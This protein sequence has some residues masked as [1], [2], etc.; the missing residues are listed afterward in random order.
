MSQPGEWSPTGFQ[1]S[2]VISA[3]Y[4]CTGH[5]LHVGG[6]PGGAAQWWGKQ[7]GVVRPP[8]YS[9]T[10]VQKDWF[11]LSGWIWSDGGLS[12]LQTINVD[13]A[14][15]KGL[16]DGRSYSHSSLH[17]VVLHVSGLWRFNLKKIT[18]CWFLTPENYAVHLAIVLKYKLEGRPIP[19]LLRWIHTWSG[20]SDHCSWSL[21]LAAFTTLGGVEG[22]REKLASNHGQRT[23]AM[24]TP[25]CIPQWGRCT[26]F[27]TL[28]AVHYPLELETS[29][30]SRSIIFNSW[31]SSVLHIK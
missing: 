28:K 11:N 27:H 5:D 16:L 12:L 7:K 25:I 10:L 3:M 24:D 13:W 26:W 15:E 8:L 6:H 29:G 31:F 1:Q 30:F 9:F 22:R 4:P 14:Q 23:R 18:Q 19:Q 17:M 20:S 21:G 2:W